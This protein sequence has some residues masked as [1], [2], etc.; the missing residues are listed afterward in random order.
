[1]GKANE[2][3]E[4]NEIKKGTMIVKIVGDSDLVLCKKARSYERVFFV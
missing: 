3:M 2:V 4:L 1:M